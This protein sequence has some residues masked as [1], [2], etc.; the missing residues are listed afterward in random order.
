MYL[1]SSGHGDKRVS[2]LIHDN[3]TEKALVQ[4][5]AGQIS[6][7]SHLF[8]VDFEYY[9]FVTFKVTG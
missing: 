4:T 2:M 1:N 7:C 5:T 3:D 8:D 9:V 6:V